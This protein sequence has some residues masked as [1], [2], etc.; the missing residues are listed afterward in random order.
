[1]SFRCTLKHDMKI[2]VL[3]RIQTILLH[4]HKNRSWLSKMLHL[5]TSEISSWLHLFQ[6]LEISKDLLMF[7]Y[8]KRESSFQALLFVPMIFK[9][10]WPFCLLLQPQTIF[11]LLIPNQCRLLSGK[12]HHTPWFQWLSQSLLWIAV[13]CRNH[14]KHVRLHFIFFFAC[15]W[16]FWLGLWQLWDLLLSWNWSSSIAFCDR[17]DGLF[18]RGLPFRAVRLI[19]FYLT[20]TRGKI[21]HP[22]T[23]LAQTQRRSMAC[24]V[25]DT[26]W[27]LLLSSGRSKALP[28]YLHYHWICLWMT[29]FW[30]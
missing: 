7:Q 4:L 24:M 2:M 19:Q 14:R 11:L 9:D 8:R 28:F 30:S 15:Q 22:F 6:H 29:W 3:A 23:F 12:E 13:V 18:I 16:C 25:W 17:R 1:M 27:V 10:E 26:W 20:L 5:R 21:E